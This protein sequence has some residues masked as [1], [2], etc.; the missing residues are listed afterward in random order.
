M[1]GA[2]KYKVRLMAQRTADADRRCM[3]DTIDFSLSL[4]LSDA[5]V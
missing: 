4:S 3:S 1:T 5:Q 2:R